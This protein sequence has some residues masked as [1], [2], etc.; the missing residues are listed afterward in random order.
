ML[1]PF[2]MM[3]FLLLIFDVKN[4]ATCVCCVAKMDKMMCSMICVVKQRVLILLLTHFDT[5]N[6]TLYTVT[7]CTTTT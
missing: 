7:K 4:V 3:C 1:S 6:K 5:K 2:L